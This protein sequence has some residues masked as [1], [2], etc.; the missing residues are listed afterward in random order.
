MK[1]KKKSRLYFSGAILVTLTFF[2]I[3]IPYLSL[4][5]FWDEAW[6]YIPAVEWMRVH[7]PGLLPG[8]IPPELSRGHPL[9][10]YFLASSWQLIF[11]NS[12]TATHV[13]PLLISC[14][15]MLALFFFIKRF[16]DEYIALTTIILVAC[17]QIFFVQSGLL[18][19][20]IIMALWTI[21]VL[22]SW[23]ADRKIL[24]F[25]FASL[26]LLTKESGFA[27]I[28]AI[29]IVQA[30]ILLLNKEKKSPGAILLQLSA[31][32]SPLIF[33]LIFFILQKLRFGWVF[34]PE[35]MDKV[36]FDPGNIYST[37]KAVLNII[38]IND[39]RIFMLI[40]LIFAILYFLV[41]FKNFIRMK[42][43]LKKEMLILIY[44]LVFI[45]FY[46][47]FCI[48][49]FFTDRYLL[50]ILPLFVFIF[51]FLFIKLLPKRYLHIPVFSVLLF[52]SVFSFF[53]NTR[54]QDVSICYADVVKVHHS[55]VKFLED[56]NYYEKRMYVP[57]LMTFNL[58]Y[59]FLGYLSGNKNFR[60]LTTN[61]K[62]TSFV[63]MVLSFD[64]DTAEFY[65]FQRDNNLKLLRR[66]E[67][68]IVNTE[69]YI[70]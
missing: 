10:F 3:K 45:V 68:G 48:I 53:R 8:A 66:F 63:F 65:Q 52:L 27:L 36:S 30:G 26:M 25:I 60:N 16:F 12:P 55:A 21:L 11:G 22:H 24:Y 67:K 6:S 40:A 35:H 18:L 28:A 23:L 57:Y 54:V 17:M 39:G 38:F 4:P 32:L 9:L 29:F 2:V 7:G 15:F 46:I 50:A 49:N 61:L 31:I 56:N 14:A 69:I 58:R 43:F 5:Y 33:P 59:K 37:L 47:A 19:P 1:T 41:R 51:V 34:F 42:V 70:P 13:F 20:E 44:F 62:D 64:S